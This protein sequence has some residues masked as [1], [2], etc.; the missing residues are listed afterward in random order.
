MADKRSEDSTWHE[1][2]RKYANYF[3]IGHN[4]Y[5]FLFDFGQQYADGKRE[6]MHTR[7][8]ASPLYAKELLQVL[9]DSIE[10]YEQKFGEIKQ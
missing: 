3:E 7:M 2:E 4:S 8:V 6:Q 5:E 10:Q 1:I 9:K